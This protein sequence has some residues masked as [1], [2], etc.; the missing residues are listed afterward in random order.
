MFTDEQTRKERLE[1]CKQCE[2]KRDNF[3]LFN[4][5]LF[6]REPQ[7]KICKCFIEQKIKLEIAQCPKDKW[8]K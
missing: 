2:F 3:M 7:C 5:I 6:K 4:V 1:T 8:V